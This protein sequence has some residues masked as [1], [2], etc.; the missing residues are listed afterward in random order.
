MTVFK[1][2]ID[3]WQFLKL[4]LI[5]Q[6]QFLKLS[7]IDQWQFWKVSRPVHGCT[8]TESVIDQWHFSRDLAIV[9]PLQKCHW[10]MTVFPQFSIWGPWQNC[11]WSI[12]DN[13]PKHHWHTYSFTK[14]S[15][16]NQWQFWKVS[17]PVHGCTF[18]KVSLTIVND[19]FSLTPWPY[20]LLY[21]SVIDWSMTICLW[22]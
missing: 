19:I 12:N 21:K 18:T 11:H 13:F 2:V 20:G 1:I 4:S 14:L 22:P 6:W 16:I 5:D 9:A 7:L 15:L 8:F 3:Q 17:R 10:S